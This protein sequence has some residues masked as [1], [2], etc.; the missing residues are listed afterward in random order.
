MRC[1]Q[2]RKQYDPTCEPSRAV[3]E[4]LARCAR[5]RQE[6][7]ELQ[8]LIALLRSE[9]EVAV[10][11]DFNRQLHRRLEAVRTRSSSWWRLGDMRYA[12]PLAAMLV[13]AVATVIFVN[14]PDSGT[15][16]QPGPSLRRA[17]AR[18]DEDAAIALKKTEVAAVRSA[19]PRTPARASD[20][21][22]PSLRAGRAAS[23]LSEEAVSRMPPSLE[24][25]EGSPII[26]L[27]R[28]PSGSEERLVRLPSLV[29]GAGAKPMTLSL[30]LS[31]KETENV[32]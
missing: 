30:S 27:I 23:V 13:L 1:E 17:P 25:S 14:R 15:A 18:L 4:H 6:A 16:P 20:R 29:V 10:P 28:E 3:A 26:L 7:T 21:S 22:S 11:A 32:F 24:G 2:V 5:C 31:E 9:P 12:L 8:Q 19:T